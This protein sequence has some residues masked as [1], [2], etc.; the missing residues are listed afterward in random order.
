MSWL[1]KTRFEGYAADG[2]RRLNFGGGGDVEAP[3]YTPVAEASKASAETMERLGNRQMDIA[4]HQYDINRALADKVVNAQLGIMDQAKSQGDDYFEYMKTNQRPLEALLNKEAMEA[5]SETA[6]NEAVGRAVADSQGGYTRSLNQMFRQAK[7][8]G[9]NTS[10]TGS[11]AVQQAQG[12]AAA[13]TAARDKE[14]NIGYAKK[15]DVAG[16]YRGLTGASQGAYSVATGA[17]NSA[18][19]NNAQ[20]GRDYMAGIGQGAN[21]VYQ[22][23][24]LN[25]Q[26][27]SNVLNSQTSFA[28]SSMNQ[29]SGMGGAGAMLG[30]VA[31]MYSAF[32]DRRLKE[33][34]VE[35]G[36]D[37]ATGLPL[38]EFNYI[39]DDDQ[40][41]RGVM[42]DE[43]LEY[44]P[45]AVSYL[46]GYAQ[47]DYGMLGIQMEKV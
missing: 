9:M 28:N 5:G 24:A 42:A 31:Q 4:E 25:L 27:L 38:Y 36:T 43:V 6:Q 20:P 15:M 40:R 35:S 34:I 1:L 32:S 13:A 23:R 37:E 3:D 46:D 39:G 10:M 11:M 26:G 22:G 41:Y 21:S 29:D 33:N 16:M 30:G 17:G 18:T 8:Y 2:R 14:K 7:R 47:V 12:T 19:Q 44:M 45:N